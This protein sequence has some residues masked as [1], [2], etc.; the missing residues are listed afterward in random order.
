MNFRYLMIVSEVSG[1]ENMIIFC[2]VTCRTRWKVV[3]NSIYDKSRRIQF[4]KVSQY[5]LII[6]LIN[7]S[8]DNMI[9]MHIALLHYTTTVYAFLF[10]RIKYS[11][12]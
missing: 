9:H 4:R 6:N 2:N 8:W 12:S 1:G 10:I 3:L 11:C 5:I 7:M